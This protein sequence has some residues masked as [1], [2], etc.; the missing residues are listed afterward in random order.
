MATGPT[1]YWSPLLNLRHDI[2]MKPITRT[3]FVRWK[4]G[5]KGGSQV[6]ST[7]NRVDFLIIDEDKTFRDATRLLIDGEGHYAESVASGELGLALGCLRDYA[8]PGNLR[9][10]RNAIERATILGR[11]DRVV[12][13]DFPAELR[14]SARGPNHD[15]LSGRA[16][17]SISLQKLDE[18]HFRRILER[19]SNFSEA[20]EVLGLDRAT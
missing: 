10:L 5:L 2:W 14:N 18:L 3:A 13:E 20:A 17:S 4:G 15:D 8:W 9:E 7:E 12:A 19:T 11:S 1:K 16:G 6:V